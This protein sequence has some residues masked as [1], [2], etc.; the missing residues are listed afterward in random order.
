MVARILAL[1]YKSCLF[2]NLTLS[3]TCDTSLIDSALHELL[4]PEISHSVCLIAEESI[5]EFDLERN[6]LRFA[7]AYRKRE[8]IAGRNCARA[9]LAQ[10]GF[11]EVPILSDDDG[12][13]LWPKGAIAC[14]SHSKGY[15][16]AIAGLRSDFR[17]LGLDLEKTNRLSP[18][19][20]ERTVHPDEQAFVQSD[21][22]K[23]S[24][25]FCAKE[26]FFKAQY[27]QWYTHGN[28]HDLVLDVDVAA[29]RLHVASISERFP[30]ELRALA[31]KLQFRYQ[32]V[33]DF[34]VVACWLEAVA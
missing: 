15:C 19:A 20:I 14:I 34:V 11:P 4:V 3:H 30:D 29:G 28:F 22:K 25:I 17:S 2:H 18:A 21:Q 26:A 12:I 32:F 6:S 7:R 31:P 27:P 8:F 16:A 33:E 9:A 13:P 10:Q 23:A 24:L 1:S 5:F